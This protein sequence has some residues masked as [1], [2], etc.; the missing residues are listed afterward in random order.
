M[1]DPKET[2]KAAFGD[3]LQGDSEFRG[4]LTL[5]VA[6]DKIVEICQFCRDEAGLLYNYLSDLS[7]LD[8]YPQEPRFCINYHLLS[9]RYNRRLRLKAFWSDGDADVPT[10][11]GLWPNANWM[12]REVYD[13]YGI[14]FADHPDLRRIL[15]PSDW[16][17][18]PLR[19]DYP[20]GYETVQ[21]SFNF[22]EVNKHKPFA[23]K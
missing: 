10:L 15:M 3:A 21:F 23:K 2:I 12:E 6:A 17:G 9:M 14:S 18:Y 20:L 19:K 13:L 16:E 11:S 4:E 8:Y 7:G 1:K 22:D 5:V